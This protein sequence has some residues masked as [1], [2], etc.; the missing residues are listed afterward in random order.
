MGPA[1]RA[2]AGVDPQA[3]HWGTADQR[4]IGRGGRAQARPVLWIAAFFGSAG[5]ADAGKNG[6]DAT[7]QHVAAGAGRG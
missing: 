6:F 3:L 7:R 2:V 1:Q 4:N 5:V